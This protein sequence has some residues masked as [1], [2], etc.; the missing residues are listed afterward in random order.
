MRQENVYKIKLLKLLEILR[1]DSDDEHYIVTPEILEKL[2]SMG[3]TC[4]I[5]ENI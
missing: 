4:D 3:I 1:Q 2:A 5:M